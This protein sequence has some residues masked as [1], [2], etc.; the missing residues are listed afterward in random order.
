MVED[1]LGKD[2]KLSHTVME[3]SERSIC[4]LPKIKVKRMK[5]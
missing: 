1:W 4:I 3:T 5:L 2:Q